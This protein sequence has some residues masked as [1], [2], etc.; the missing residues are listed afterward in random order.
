MTAEACTGAVTITDR[1]GKERGECEGFRGLSERILDRPESQKHSYVDTKFPL[2]GVEKYSR[3]LLI[4]TETNRK[5]VKDAPYC[6]TTRSSK[7]QRPG[8][9]PL[10]TWVGPNL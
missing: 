8:L 1:D 5:Y 10:A 2:I 6:Q 4:T 9:P 7:V 3:S